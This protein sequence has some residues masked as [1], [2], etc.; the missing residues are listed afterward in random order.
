MPEIIEEQGI[1]L[2]RLFS[3]TTPNV[4]D[5]GR[6]TRPWSGETLSTWPDQGTLHG[7]INTNWIS[8]QWEVPTD[9]QLGKYK[10]KMSVWNIIENRKEPFITYEDDFDVIEPKEQ[11]EDFQGPH[12]KKE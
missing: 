6:Y 1:A 10:V 2:H 11:A 12:R 7:E 5:D 8:W 3:N 9:C 4:S